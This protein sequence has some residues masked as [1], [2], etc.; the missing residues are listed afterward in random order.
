VKFSA[1][2]L[3]AIRLLDWLLFAVIIG[4]SLVPPGF[5]PETSVPHT[6]EHA[7]IFFLAG[8]AFGVGYAGWRSI[9][10]PAAIVFCAAIQLAQ[11]L[12]PGRHARWSDF[13]ADAAAACIGI[14]VSSLGGWATPDNFASCKR[15]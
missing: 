2:W 10:Y 13:L 1:A 9:L 5:R 12:V 7:V 4:L 14:L 15:S 3:Q 6:I 11:L 8:G